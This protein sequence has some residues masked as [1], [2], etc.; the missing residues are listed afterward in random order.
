MRKGKGGGGAREEEGVG[1]SGVFFFFKITCCGFGFLEGIWGNEEGERVS[2]RMTH[3][4]KAFVVFCFCSG[5][6]GG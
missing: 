4:R 3:A 1:E 5:S 6:G 2:A